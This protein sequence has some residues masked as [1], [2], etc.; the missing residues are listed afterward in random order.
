MSTNPNV[1]AGG[2]IFLG[3]REG[4]YT[5]RAPK[6]CGH[7]SPT[8][9][10]WGSDLP[11]EIFK[12]CFLLKFQNY[13]K[14][15]KDNRSPSTLN[16]LSTSNTTIFRTVSHIYEYMAVALFYKM[17]KKKRPIENAFSIFSRKRKCQRK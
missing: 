3:G 17:R 5:N 10:G 14:S 9:F 4:W 7:R 6:T 12:P 2:W 16:Y 15:E 8:H 13:K 11:P 1:D